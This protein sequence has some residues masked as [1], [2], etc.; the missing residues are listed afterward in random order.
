MRIRKFI[1]RA[2]WTVIALATLIAL[3][4]AEEDWRGARAWQA[5]Q[6]EYAK[7]GETLDFA[8]FVPPPIPD[9]QNLAA[10]PLFTLQPYTKEQPF[11]H[12]VTLDKALRRN[13]NLP[14][15][16]SIGNLLS[17]KLADL[18]AIRKGV[19]AAYATVFKGKAPPASPRSQFEMVYPFIAELRDASATRP[20]CRFNVDYLTNPPFQRSLELLTDQITV[21]K[22][23]ALDVLLALDAHEAGI[24]L[25]DIRTI[26]TLASGATRDPSLVGGLVAIGMKTIAAT[27]ISNGLALHAWNDSQLA[28][29]QAHLGEMDFLSDF[30]AGIRSEAAHDVPNFD[31]FRKHP[32]ILETISGMMDSITENFKWEAYSIG[33][34]G[35]LDDNEAQLVLFH[36]ELLNTIDPKAHRLYLDRLQKSTLEAEP[37]SSG[38]M[39]PWNLFFRMAVAPLP[40]IPILY[41]QAQTWADHS[42]IACALERFRLAHGHYPDSLDP[43]CPRYCSRIPRDVVNGEPTHY[44]L[45]SD[46]SYRLYSIGANGKD[47]GGENRLLERIHG[48]V[49][50]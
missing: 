29:L 25:D 27:A 12:S 21:A 16:P 14:N 35:W 28:Q 11:P 17:G 36:L 18:A 13:E 4:Y 40:R 10:L 42:V 24:A 47:D 20:Y 15:L 46:G 19:A 48:H 43:L 41:A 26:L 33:P 39:A 2:I 5:A 31:Y 50:R 45:F 34:L 38:I 3:F 9:N 37:T 49:T 1:R 32:S 44:R 23:L 8:K 30:Q 6:A 22:L 7:R